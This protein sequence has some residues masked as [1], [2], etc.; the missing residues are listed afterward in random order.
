VIHDGAISS[1]NTTAF[2]SV[3]V[4]LVVLM[5]AVSLWR[6]IVLGITERGAPPP[7]LD[8]WMFPLFGLLVLGAVLAFIVPLRH[9]RIHDGVFWVRGSGGEIDV[10]F[11]LVVSIRQPSLLNV[12]PVTVTLREAVP[13]LGH[14]F[15]FLPRAADGHLTTVDAFTVGELR[16]TVRARTGT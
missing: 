7:L 1:R 6:A 8:T 3:V 13:G 11:A 14:R 4:G 15:R 2:K 12:R 9:V 16:A 10:P 5:T